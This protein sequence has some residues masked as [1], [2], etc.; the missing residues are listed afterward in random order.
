MSDQILLLPILFDGV[1]VLSNDSC[2]TILQVKSK[3]EIDDE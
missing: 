2:D 3:S 1:A